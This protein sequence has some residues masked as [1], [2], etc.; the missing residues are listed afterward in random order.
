MAHWGLLHRKQTN[1]NQVNYFCVLCV[2]D[3][4]L[5]ST[6]LIFGI[7]GSLTL[8][9]GPFIRGNTVLYCTGWRKGHMTIEATH[10]TSSVK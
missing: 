8:P 6:A 3:C 7:N 5:Y 10:Y 1:K 2:R 4:S 9:I